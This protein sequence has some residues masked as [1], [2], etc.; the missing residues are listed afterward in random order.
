MRFEFK[1]RQSVPSFAP[2]S[3]EYY[4]HF[5]S[6]HGRELQE[7]RNCDALCKRLFILD[8]IARMDR[9]ILRRNLEFFVSRYAVREKPPPHVKSAKIKDPIVLNFIQ[10][11]G[12]DDNSDKEP[13]MSKELDFFHGLLE[14]ADHRELSRTVQQFQEQ[15]EDEQERFWDWRSEIFNDNT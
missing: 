9:F 2:W 10:K 5:D 8:Q 6:V 1:R 15:W 11:Y 7:W 3:A 14:D 4:N 13:W 12:G